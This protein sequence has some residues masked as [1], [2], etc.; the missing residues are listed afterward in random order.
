MKKMLPGLCNLLG[1]L[2]LLLII[3]VCLPLA[4]PRFAGY[5]VYEVVSGSMEPEI[6]VGSVVYVKHVVPD[7]IAEEE[8]IAFWSDSSV[9]VHRVMQNKTVEGEFVTKGDANDAEDLRAIPY[10]DLI[11]RVEYHFPVIGRLM[12]L[13]AMR[14]GKIYLFLVA[15]CGVMLNMLAGILRKR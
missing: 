7:D 3:A 2:I 4:I 13:Y 8:V 11:G 15:A 6:P 10:S 9:I 5:E 12:S 14:V 1:T